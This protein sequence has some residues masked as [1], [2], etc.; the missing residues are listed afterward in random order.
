MCC[1]YVARMMLRGVWK[2]INNVMLLIYIKGDFFV[3]LVVVL[4]CILLPSIYFTM[5]NQI[6]EDASGIAHAAGAV[7][8]LQDEGRTVLSH[9]GRD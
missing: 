1:T 5:T 9:R 2:R 4:G 6:P 3:R 7:V 8:G